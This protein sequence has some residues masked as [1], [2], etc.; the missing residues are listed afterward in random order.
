VRWMN[1]P[2]NFDGAQ[3]GLEGERECTRKD[4][5]LG[6]GLG[7]PIVKGIIDAHAVVSGWRARPR[8]WEHVLLHDS[9]GNP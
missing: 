5:R 1:R 7:L 9:A 8:T 2:R 6:A 4:S 3:R